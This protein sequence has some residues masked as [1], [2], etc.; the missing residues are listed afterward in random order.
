MASFANSAEGADLAAGITNSKGN[1]ATYVSASGTSVIRGVLVQNP[2]TMFD[3]FQD[4]FEGRTV[5]VPLLEK[6][7]FRPEHL[8]LELYGT[9]DLWHV[10]LKINNCLNHTHF[11]F[12][13]V[14]IVSPDSVRDL[15]DL[16]GN[17]ERPRD[18]VIE[19][20]LALYP[21]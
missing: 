10:L 16:M 3:Q 21:V 14:R 11:D 4:F 7:R 19:D 15:A 18:V 17:V 20:N 2:T 1:P 5:L 9:V 6:H 13:E 12:P 8:S